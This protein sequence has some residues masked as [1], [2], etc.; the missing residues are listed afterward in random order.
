MPKKVAPQDTSMYVYRQIYQQMGFGHKPR[1]DID[2]MC[3]AI[4]IGVQCA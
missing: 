1:I 4:K 2:P 3:I